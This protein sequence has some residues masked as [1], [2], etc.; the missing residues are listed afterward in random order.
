MAILLNAITEGLLWAPMAIGIYITFR[1]LKIA[2]L[3]SEGS[4]PLGAAVATIFITKGLDPLVSTLLAFLVGSLAGMVTGLLMTKGKVPSI[5]AGILV[6][7]G[8]YSINLRIMGRSNVSL[9]NEPRITD[10][11]DR[12]FDL[13]PFLGTMLVA[14]IVLIIII[15]SLAFFLKVDLGQ[16]LIATGDNTEMARAMGINTDTMTILGL[17]L[18]NG[19][20]A[21]SGALISQ[22][23]GYADISMGIGTLVIGL[24][25]VIIAEIFFKNLTLG[26]R[27]ISIPVGSILYRFVTSFVL[28]LGLN[29]NDLKLL[30]AIILGL[31]LSLPSLIAERKQRKIEE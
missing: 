18:S 13:P 31:F 21:L 12:F 28:T 30:S 14:L 3:T 4:Y 10:F 9:L 17:S 22:F 8:L 15:A 5:L 25:G 16:A 27:L 23:N 24:A 29:P 7:T 6:M 11:F 1:I 2:D 20:I 19:L 26:E